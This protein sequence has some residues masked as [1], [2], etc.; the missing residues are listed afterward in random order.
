MICI[1]DPIVDEKAGYDF[2]RKAGYKNESQSTDKPPRPSLFQ[3]SIAAIQA[4]PAGQSFDRS[5]LNNLLSPLL[6]IVSSWNTVVFHMDHQI[7]ALED[8]LEHDY[9]DTPQN[10]VSILHKAQRLSR[11]IT[12]YLGQINSMESDIAWKKAGNALEAVEIDAKDVTTNL[13][14][15]LLRTD[16][17]VPALLAS[18]A[19]S[20]GAKASSLTAIVLWFAPLSLAISIVSIDGHAP[21]GGR[22]FWIMAC[23]AIPLLLLV[24]AVANTS[25]SF[26]ALLGRRRGGRALLSLFKPETRV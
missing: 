10:P 24:I 13:N 6:S 2:F 8:Q 26:I 21:F 9:W 11:R 7:S 1:C 23:I 15:L 17:A 22:K 14:V 12:A 25:D 3:K 4:L 20:E 5:I 19:I 16:K 18:I